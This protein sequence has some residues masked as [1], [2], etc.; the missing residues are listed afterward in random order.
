MK[1]KWMVWIGVVGLLLLSGCGLWGEGAGQ[2][3]P[4]AERPF[5]FTNVTQ[6]VGID[7]VHGAFRWGMSGD[8]VAMMGGGLCWVDYDQ[9][10]WLDLYAINS[11]AEAE[12]GQWEANGGLPRNKL[13]RNMGGVFVDVSTA[14]GA[15]LALRGNGCTAA[16][17]NLDGYPDIYITTARFNALL[18]NN[19]DGTFTE[20]AEAAGV[21]AYGWQTAVSVADLNRDNLPDLFVA[22]Y[23][24]VNNR[25]PDATKG[26]PNTN[27]GLRD[28]LYINN[29]LDAAGR[30]T[31]R[32]VGEAVGL[33][34]DNFAYGLGSLLTDVDGDGDLD[35]LIAND[36]NPN[37]LYENVAWSDG[38][39][40]LGLG[41]RLVERGAAAQV[42]DTNS[43]MGV[44]G[45][46][47]DENGRFD[48][49]ITNMGGQIHSLYRHGDGLTFADAAGQIGVAEFG[50]TLTGW[51][52]SWADFDL[53]TDLDL[54]IIQGAIPV[55]DLARDRQTAQILVNLTAQGR[56]GQL[57]DRSQAAGLGYVGPL[58]GRGAAVADY[59]N[60]GDMD[61]AIGTI[62]GSLALLRNEVTGGNWLA[63]AGVAA[64]GEITA[65]LPDGRELRRELYGG[66]SYLSAEDPRAHFGLGD[67]ETI[68]LL[69]VR[70][71]NG[72]ITE[73][74]NVAANQLLLV[75]P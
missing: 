62:G 4:V 6:A 58:L 11:Y 12:A 50:N 5:H 55:L 29:G 57:E 30:T 61:I 14:S 35:L 10:G 54:A 9:D 1:N 41:F 15:D 47:F 56:P 51:G 49:V 75:E 26:F 2:T 27:L 66:S 25:I 60:D 28:L 13:Y 20:G 31:F 34:S 68:P 73:Q 17:F 63:V 44:A 39:D 70:W 8:P 22:G 53:D 7:F 32:E 43:G 21:D 3:V 45:G 36:T 24:D 59:D 65:V 69:R 16:D 23:V 46:D 74:Q 42:N 52:T 33:E 40:P 48:L 67:V 37:Y 19:G 38:V 18:W 64:G 71:P 72:T